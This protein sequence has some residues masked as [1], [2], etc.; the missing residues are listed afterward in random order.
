MKIAVIKTGGKQYKVKTGEKIKV[1]KLL[2]EKE[3]IIKLDTLLIADKDKVELGTPQLK[4]Q[5]EAKVV[6]QFRAKKIRV[7]K[8]KSKTR[9]HKVYGHRQHLTELEIIKI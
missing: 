3:Q 5:V 6:R 9:Y 4:D 1:E 8:Y 2:G 7:V